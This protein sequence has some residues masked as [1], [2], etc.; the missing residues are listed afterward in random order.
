MVENSVGKRLYKLELV[1]IKII[2]Y[3][4]GL[5]YLGNTISSYVYEELPIFSY[6]GGLSILPLIFIYL[7]S[8]VFKFC[9]YHRLPLYYVFISDCISY[10]DMYIGIP[11]SNRNLFAI[12]MLIAGITIFLIIFLK[13][14]LCAHK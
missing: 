5:C 1:S 9:I 8:F 6:I 2:P 7:S 12:N 11:L 14:K 13:F 10:Y 4:I 3:L